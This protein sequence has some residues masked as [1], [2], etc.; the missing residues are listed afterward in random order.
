MFY[1]AYQLLV[2]APLL[3]IITALT[4]IATIIGCAVGPA[5]WWSYY[6]GRL[7]ARAFVRILLLP[8]EVTGREN[9]QPGQ[10][11]VIVPNHQG[12]FD[13]FLVYGFLNRHFKW[14]MKHELRSIPLVGRACESS[15]FIFVDN[16][17]P[18]RIK[19]T[20]DRAREILKEGISV[21]VFPEGARTLDGEMQPFKRGA[22]QLADELSLPLLPVTING[23]YDVLPRWRGVNFVRRHKLSMTIHAPIPSTTHGTEAEHE[24]MQRTRDIIA[25]ALQPTVTVNCKLSNCKL[26][27]S[28]LFL[29]SFSL[30]FALSSCQSPATIHGTTSLHQ[31]EGRTIYIKVYSEGTLHDIDSARIVHGRFAMAPQVD[32]PV[33]GSIFIGTESLMPIVLDAEELNV[34]IGEK[35]NRVSG[36][37]LNDSLFAFIKRKSEVDDLISQLPHRETQLIMDGMDHDE[38]LRQLSAEAAVLNAREDQIVTQ[39]I[40]RNMDNPL[41]PGVFMILTSELPYP[42]LTPQIEE[43]I[44]LASQRFLDDPY[45]KDYIRMARQNEEEAIK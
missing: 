11:Y 30:T 6:P 3:I 28:L 19:E 17:G 4:S 24:V 15:G 21:V 31:L 42:M 14:M 33:M 32:D 23:S 25:S 26:H 20:Y 13:I 44:T 36:S 12:A 34:S 7:W 2:A 41:G 1:R 39:F 38:I 18:K 45:V 22:F 9:M 40:K 27:A 5:S 8:V 29:L 10:S 43:I 16:R 35:H 37:P